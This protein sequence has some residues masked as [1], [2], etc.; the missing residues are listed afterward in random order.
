MDLT[1]FSL[2]YPDEKTLKAHY[3][4]RDR[5]DIAMFELEE[6]GMLDILELRSSELSD[7]FTTD[8]P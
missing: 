2:I 3:A 4:G 7:F 1:N 5:A 8:P 6:L